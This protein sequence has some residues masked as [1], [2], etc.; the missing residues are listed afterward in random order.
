M[1]KEFLAKDFRLGSQN[2]EIDFAAMSEEIYSFDVEAGDETP[3]RCKMSRKDADAFKA[4]LKMIPPESRKKQMKAKLKEQINDKYNTL[5]QQEISVYIDRI[6]DAMNA[7]RLADMEENFL[8]YSEK[9]AAKIKMLLD[10]WYEKRFTDLLTAQ[11]IF[12]D[13]T[14][15]YQEKA[16]VPGNRSDW[17]KML[18]TGE[19][20]MNSFEQSLIEE[21]C[22]MDNILWWHRNG[23]N[24]YDKNAW[25]INGFLNHYPD[26]IVMTKKGHMV[27]VETK[28][29]QLG[30]EDNFAKARLGYLLDTHDN[31][32]MFSYF[33]VFEKEKPERPG[34]KSWQEFL[35]LLE[36]W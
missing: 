12:V 36:K 34:C 20:K 3:K 30:N 28:G 18:Y 15:A 11:D 10:N 9:V 24:Q 23:E 27:A 19:G 8:A 16:I 14:F 22:G 25:C 7:E 4:A 1:T 13:F 5:S 26:F 31:N 17:K 32:D 35:S 29:E 21:V 2:T 33:M 6:V